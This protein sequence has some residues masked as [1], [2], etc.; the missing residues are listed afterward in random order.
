MTFP[1]SLSKQFGITCKSLSKQDYGVNIENPS[2]K[3]I[4]FLVVTD[5]DPKI[6]YKYISSLI[7]K[8]PI[9][10]LSSKLSQS[11]LNLILKHDNNLTVTVVLYGHT[12]SVLQNVYTLTSI[13]YDDI[14]Y[15]YLKEGI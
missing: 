6:G 9:F 14:A 11:R 12:Y 15:I 10:N 2:K 5:K 1:F 7:F 3:V 13:L 4:Y 8:S